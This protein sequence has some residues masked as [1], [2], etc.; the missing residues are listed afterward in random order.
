M[1]QKTRTSA[2]PRRSPDSLTYLLRAAFFMM[3][4]RWWFE[5][6][7]DGGCPQHNHALLLDLYVHV[8]QPSRR[9][10]V[11]LKDEWRDV[12]EV[13]LDPTAR[14]NA[15]TAKARTIGSI[16]GAALQQFSTDPAA[17]FPPLRNTYPTYTVEQAREIIWDISE[18]NFR[19]EL[20]ALD[21]RAS[22]RTREDEVT[23]CFPGGMLLGIPREH[24]QQGVALPDVEQRHRYIH[25]IAL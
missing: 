1:T 12:L 17:D 8:G 6:R 22:L 19:F 2:F 14:R 7:V 13:R 23:R 3:V 11:L 9:R 5:S 21:K 25:H 18:T 15:R 16:I 10:T 20:M 24:A 4:V